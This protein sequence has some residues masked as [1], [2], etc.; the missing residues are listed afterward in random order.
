MST[1]PQLSSPRVQSSQQ[2][3]LPV[4]TTKVCYFH[5]TILQVSWLMVFLVDCFKARQRHIISPLMESSTSA[6][7]PVTSRAKRTALARD[8][9]NGVLMRCSQ[10]GPGRPSA[11]RVAECRLHAKQPCPPL[12]CHAHAQPTSDTSRWTLDQALPAHLIW[13]PKVSCAASYYR[14]AQLTTWAPTEKVSRMSPQMK[15]WKLQHGAQ[16]NMDMSCNL[17]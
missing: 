10:C 15:Y 17:M 16:P 12:S 2:D 8:F 7:F 1:C 11:V 3:A 13:A 4:L 5:F 14:G 6:T 9:H